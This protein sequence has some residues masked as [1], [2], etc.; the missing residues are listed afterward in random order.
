MTRPTDRRGAGDSSA[1][2][3]IAIGAVT[4]FD[5]EVFRIGEE[6]RGVGHRETRC[7]TFGSSEPVLASYPRARGAENRTQL[8]RQLHPR[9]PWA[10]AFCTATDPHPVGL[11]LTLG[12]DGARRVR[13][14]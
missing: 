2:S 12:D 13:Q 3:L 9:F 8:A 11:D 1:G 7:R 14:P 4:V 5:I 10:A 6:G